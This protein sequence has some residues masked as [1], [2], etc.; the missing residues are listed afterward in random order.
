MITE[1]IDKF[2]LTEKI[3]TNSEPYRIIMYKTQKIECCGICYYLD[4]SGFG[5][6]GY[7]ENLQNIKV[8]KK[9]EEDVMDVNSTGIC[10]RFKERK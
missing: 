3:D 5:K 7:C 4:P 9:Y 2:L 8:F 1:K 10:P 6:K